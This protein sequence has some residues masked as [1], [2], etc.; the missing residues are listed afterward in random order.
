L[1]WIN[2]FAG[3]DHAVFFYGWAGSF[4]SDAR[5]EAFPYPMYGRIVNFLAGGETVT[6][7]DNEYLSGDLELLMQ[8][9]AV[10]TRPDKAY[11][12]VVVMGKAAEGLEAYKPSLSIGVARVPTNRARTY[13]DGETLVWPYRNAP[14]QSWERTLIMREDLAQI[15]AVA[16]AIANGVISLI[17]DV[18]LQYPEVTL[19]GNPLW[20]WGDKVNF[21][22]LGVSSDLSIGL[23]SQTFRVERVT[24]SI[25]FETEDTTKAFTTNLTLSPQ[26]GVG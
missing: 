23:A 13:V 10:E 11:N 26:T 6:V 1:K 24:H 8:R 16:Q 9:V 12:R 19:R 25:D 4:F 21:K 15:P 7:T 18:K 3:F 2:D 14:E 17:K 20:Y 22:M 5:R